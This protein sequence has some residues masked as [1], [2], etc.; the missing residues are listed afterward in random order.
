[1]VVAVAYTVAGIA[2]REHF[3]AVLS[4][5]LAILSYWTAF[6]VMI[7]FEE[8]VI[9]RRSRGYDLA[10]Y[11]QVRGKC[12]LST[13]LI[14][15]SF[16]GFFLRLANCPWDLLP[17]IFLDPFPSTSPTNLFPHSA[18]ACFGVAGAVVGM[19]ETYYIGPIAKDIAMPFGG[20]L[21]FELAAAFAGVTYPP[22]R[23]LEIRMT[24]R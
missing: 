11:N 14:A 17:C 2:G 13:R 5:L 7:V 24:G 16:T 1:M 6:F 22:L 4:N 8:H 20:D 3:S 23:W 18:A 9:F 15:D 21:G 10:I 19:A 12:T